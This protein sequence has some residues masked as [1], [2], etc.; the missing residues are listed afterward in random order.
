MLGKA[1]KAFDGQFQIT[2]CMVGTFCMRIPVLLG[3]PVLPRVVNVCLALGVLQQTG[4]KLNFLRTL[5][6]KTA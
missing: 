4:W 2:S 3:L 5:F 6:G 1:S